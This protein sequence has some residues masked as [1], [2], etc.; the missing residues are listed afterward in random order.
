MKLSSFEKIS[1]DTIGY[2]Y[3][4]KMNDIAIEKGGEL[5]STKWEGNNKKYKFID[6]FGYEFEVIYSA[7]IYG[8]Q[9][10]PKNIFISESIC[11]QVFEHLFESSFDK[12]REILTGHITK[13]NRWELDGF[14]Q[15]LNIAFEYQGYPSHWDES[16]QSYEKTSKRDLLKKEHCKNLGITLIQISPFKN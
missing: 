15:E 9:W 7:L 14:C 6:Q 12:T 3:L 10:S 1:M 13:G 8:N 16:H 2:K 5:L 11:K 4:K